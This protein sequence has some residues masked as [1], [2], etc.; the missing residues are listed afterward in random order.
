[1]AK[2]ITVF[3]CKITEKISIFHEIA[4]KKIGKFRLFWEIEFYIKKSKIKPN[5]G[6]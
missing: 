6:V 1:M 4:N 2:I 5:D 3:G